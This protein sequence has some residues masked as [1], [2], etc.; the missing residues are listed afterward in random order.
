LYSVGRN[1]RHHQP[2]IRDARSE[3]DPVIADADVSQQQ[4]SQQLGN[5]ERSLSVGIDQ[6]SDEI[7]VSSSSSSS[8]AMILMDA[9]EREMCRKFRLSVFYKMALV[10]AAKRKKFLINEGGGAGGGL[11]SMT[12]HYLN[13]C[14]MYWPGLDV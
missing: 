6:Q 5:I 2:A 12:L 4:Q 13:S 3:F 14:A 7:S 11:S 1:K 8:S 10:W 9:V